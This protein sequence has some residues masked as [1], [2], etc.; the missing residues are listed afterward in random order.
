MKMD[1]SEIMNDS[2]KS[3]LGGNTWTANWELTS[4]CKISIFGDSFSEA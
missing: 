1:L 3:L 4:S 2:Y